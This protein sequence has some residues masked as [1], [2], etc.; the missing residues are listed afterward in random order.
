LLQK[1]LSWY[2]L[3]G[4]L[5]TLVLVMSI[6][7]ACSG[8]GKAIT[9]V[10]A[11]PKY[12]SVTPQKL[13]PHNTN[14]ITATAGTGGSISPSGT[15]IVQ[16]HTNKTFN[17]SPNDGYK[18]T[19]VKVDGASVGPL[20]AY[21]FKDVYADHTILATFDK[22]VK[23]IYTI[24]ATAGAN[25]SISPSGT[26]NVNEHTSQVFTIKP[27]DGYKIA[28]VQVD[29]AS[30]GAVDTYTFDDITANH[31]ISAVFAELGPT[32]LYDGTY[33]G[34]LKYT[35]RIYKSVDALGNPIWGP[36]TTATLDLTLTL[37]TTEIDPDAVTV[38][39][40]HVICT[41]PG[42]GAT[43]EG[44][45]PLNV[46]DEESSVGYLPPE[47]PVTQSDFSIVITF[48]N[49]AVLDLWNV[50]ASSDGNTLYNASDSV[51][52]WNAYNVPSGTL[53]Y[54]DNPPAYAGSEFQF[55]DWTLTK[56]SSPTT[57]W[58]IPPVN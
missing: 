4:I 54:I 18:I 5:L 14:V 22:L 58:G 33:Q 2:K 12:G 42:F 9:Q 25:G 49:G 1:N 19:D 48:P 32:S 41:E 21:T 26:V 27:S 34:T 29:G 30:V 17:I 8:G 15:V 24:T 51:T 53:L 6:L 39:V 43:G 16:V 36:W 40:T 56:V 7:A 46:S 28:D 52:P 45:T 10:Q 55:Y 47:P 44:V 13:A 57:V 20:N 37:K 35:Y 31:T 23:I 38:I 50:N 11:P 3:V